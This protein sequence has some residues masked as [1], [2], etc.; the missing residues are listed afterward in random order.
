MQNIFVILGTAP[1]W[2]DDLKA[3]KAFGKPFHIIAVNRACYNSV[4][5]IIGVVTYHPEELAEWLAIR[6]KTYSCAPLYKIAHIQHP[7]INYVSGHIAPSG[8]SSLLGAQ[9]AL[10][11]GATHVV[12]AGCDLSS[13]YYQMYQDGWNSYFPKLEGKVKAMSGW[14]AKKLGTPVGWL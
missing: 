12:M 3:M 6:A 5:P 13:P 4:E 9:A 1:S 8:T 2:Q 7:M 14:L 11:L 10:A